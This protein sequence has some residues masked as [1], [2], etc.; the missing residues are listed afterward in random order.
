MHQNKNQD[1]AKNLDGCTSICSNEIED[2][3]RALNETLE[4]V[5]R[6][7]ILFVMRDFN[8]EVGKKHTRTTIGKFGL[9]DRLYSV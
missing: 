3:Y 7:D 8:A 4:S 1:Q 5:H 6:D 9:G 2:F